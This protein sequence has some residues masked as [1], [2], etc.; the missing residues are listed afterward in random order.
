MMETAVLT[1]EIKKILSPARYRHSLSVSQ[2]AARLAKRHG[3][4]PRAAFQAGLVHDC[5]KE[6]PRAKLIRYVQK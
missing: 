3:W 2:F 4:D 6:W 1:K 5:A